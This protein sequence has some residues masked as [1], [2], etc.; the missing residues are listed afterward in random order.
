MNIEKL[1]NF[2][3]QKWEQEIIPEL[4]TFIAIPNKSPVFD[5][6]WQKHGYMQQAVDLIKDWCL[7]QDIAGMRLE[8]IAH[9]DRTPLIFME[10]P[11]Q[12]D[13][14]VLLYGH[15]DK[16]PEM[17]GWDDDL[18]PW[19]PVLK[20]DKLYGRGG[21]DDGYAAFASLTAIKALQLQ[22]IPHARCVVLI[23]ASEESGSTDL[24][25]Y[26][27]ALAEQIGTPNLVVCLDSGCGNYEQLWSTTSLRGLVNGDLTV[28]LLKEGVHSGYGSGIYASSFRVL[29]ELLSRLEDQVTGKVTVPEVQVTIPEQRI[30]Q[31][32]V[33]ANALGDNVYQCFPSHKDVEP[34]TN[35][36]VELLLNRTWRAQLSITG[37][38]GLPPLE[39]AG[40]VLRPKTAVKI[41][42]RV[43][44]TCDAKAATHAVKKLLEENVPYNAKVHFEAEQEANGWNAPVLADWLHE[45]S[46]E[47]S[48]Q[49]YGK[50]VAYMGEGGSIPFMGMLGERF[51]DA[52]FLIAGVLGPNS[53]A[54]GPNEFLHIPMGKNLTSCVA[55]V[56]AK[57]YE[58]F[59]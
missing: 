24:P 19:K 33:A 16:Q 47:A 10:I 2:V 36:V 56:V 26:V 58:A 12:I 27:D 3:N 21:A 34:V 13:E 22:D 57:H 9:G 4:K 29:R 46:D 43:P 1:Q 55:Y 23:E 5:A 39:T 45:A 42:M 17:T 54:H 40:N 28:E 7:K 20:G 59:S 35:D 41:S 6:D 32:K 18:G 15:L 53:N 25:Y 30:E 44:P 37:A 31:A 49:V 11:G 50:P 8:V 38:D 48:M 51:P 14:T 52:Q